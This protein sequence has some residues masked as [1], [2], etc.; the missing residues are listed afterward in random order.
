[1]SIVLDLPQELEIKLSAEASRHGVPLSEYV[2]Q[3]L[4]GGGHASTNVRNGTELLTYWQQ[5]GLVGTRPEI[6]DSQKY[7][8]DLRAEAERRGQ[9]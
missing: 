1:M 5:E 2:L 8:R 6:V 3:I 9:P 7:A 4:S